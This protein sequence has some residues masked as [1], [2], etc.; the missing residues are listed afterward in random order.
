VCP[1]IF[2]RFS[3]FTCWNLLHS[4]HRLE[5]RPSELI[6]HTNLGT[7]S[8]IACCSLLLSTLKNPKPKHTIQDP[9]KLSVVMHLRR[10]DI[11]QGR[12]DG[13]WLG[14]SFYKKVV[15]MLRKHLH[16]HADIHIMSQVQTRVVL[17]LV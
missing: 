5:I 7:H 4:A 11:A 1:L 8:P 9:K 16:D 13:R 6:A 10:G 2:D 12:N 17:D 14:A 15:L 3:F